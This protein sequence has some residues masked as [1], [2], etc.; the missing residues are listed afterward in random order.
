[1]NWLDLTITV[2]I[3]IGLIKGLFDGVIKQVIS[4]IS[5]IL[6]IIF[7]ERIA[8]PIRNILLKYSFFT[9]TLPDYIVTC[10]CYILAFSGI[11]IALYWLGKLLHEAIKVTPAKSLN[12]LLGGLFGI[13]KWVLFLSLLFTILTV[14]DPNSRVISKQ[15]KKESVLFNK[16]RS[17]VPALYP[18]VKNYFNYKKIN[19]ENDDR[20]VCREVI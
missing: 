7:A 2:C 14:F 5:L 18:Y 15:I 20:S 16:V 12:Y 19:E 10:I 13:F 3:S 8:E 17:I 9:D 4:F 1:M 11:V 6:A